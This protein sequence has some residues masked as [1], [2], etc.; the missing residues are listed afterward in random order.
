MTDVV[1]VKEQT[2]KEREQAE[3]RLQEAHQAE[4]NALA[5]LHSL[6]QDCRYPLLPWPCLASTT[7]AVYLRLNSGLLPDGPKLVPTM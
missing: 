4:Q 2:V 7:L 6:R 3:L 1:Q 5:H